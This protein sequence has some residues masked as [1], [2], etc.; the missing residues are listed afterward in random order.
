MRETDAKLYVAVCGPGHATEEEVAW[1]QEVGR[2]LAEAGVV[3]LTGGMGGVMD[4]AARGATEAEGTCIGILPG[5]DR[6][7]ESPH[8]S[9][10]IPS[11]LGEARNTVLVRGADAVIAISGEW[12]TLSEIALALKFQIPVVGISTWELGRRGENVEA[13][14]TAETPQA[15]VEL[16][17]K[18]ARRRG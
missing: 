5:M 16:A 7:G 6:E 1:A 8:L 12:G 2:L 17:L 3:V 10:S 11:G 14:E 15:A 18:R 9:F 4:A 13:F